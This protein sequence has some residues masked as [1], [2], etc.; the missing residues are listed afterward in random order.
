MSNTMTTRPCPLLL[1]KEL[2][3]AS[4]VPVTEGGLSAVPVTEIYST[5]RAKYKELFLSL[6]WYF[7]F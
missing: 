3:A 5:A 7:F 6:T 2:F 4:F 1:I